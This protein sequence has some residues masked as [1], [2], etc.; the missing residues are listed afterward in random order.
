[1]DARKEELFFTQ[2]VREGLSDKVT[3]EQ[4]IF[5]GNAQREFQEGTGVQRSLGKNMPDVSEEGQGKQCNWSEV[6]QGSMIGGEIE[7]VMEDVVPQCS[8]QH[9][10]FIYRK[11]WVRSPVEPGVVHSLLSPKQLGRPYHIGFV[12][13]LKDIVFFF[14]RGAGFKMKNDII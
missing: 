7:G 1:M 2:G 3:F 4:K 13:H 11:S 8:G 5:H 10:C 12:S 9:I 14:E 6:R